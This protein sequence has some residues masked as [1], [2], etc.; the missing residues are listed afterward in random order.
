VVP[1]LLLQL[2]LLEAGVQTVTRGHWPQSST[3][4]MQAPASLQGLNLNTAV[5]HSMHSTAGWHSTVALHHTG[6]HTWPGQHPPLPAVYC[7]ST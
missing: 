6:K 5:Q 1:P 3:P 7:N 2:L 4:W